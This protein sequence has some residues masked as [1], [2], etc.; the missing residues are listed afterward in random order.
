MKNELKSMFT[1]HWKYLAV[2]AACK[3]NLFDKI[4]EGQNTLEKLASKN[5]YAIISEVH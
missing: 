4:Y 2:S 3:L 5:N 1:E